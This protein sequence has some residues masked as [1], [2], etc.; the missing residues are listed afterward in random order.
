MPRA[1][2][3]LIFSICLAVSAI[4]QGGDWRQYSSSQAGFKV[5]FPANWTAS[6]E[7][8]W[9]AGHLILQSPEVFDR[10]VMMSAGIR[11]CSQ[12]KG[13]ISSSSDGN[14][15]CRL[16]DDHLSELYKNK[17]VSEEILEI[18]GVKIRKTISQDKYRPDTV[19]IDAFFSTNERDVMINGGFPKKFDL[20]KYVPVFDQIITTIQILTNFTSLTYSNEKYGFSLT[21]PAS[22]RSCALDFRRKKEDI[23]LLVPENKNCAGANSIL[24]SLPSDERVDPKEILS[25]QSFSISAADWSIN[26]RISGSKI[27]D[28]YYYR[29]TYLSFANRSPNLVLVREMYAIDERKCRDEALGILLS[30][31]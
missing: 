14:S 21:Y 7:W 11:I 13:Y 17:I 25:K 1:L 3:L 10:D 2:V 26:S 18:S 12:P 31:K 20:E 27:D 24:I 6:E 29:E 19:Y 15:R 5:K 8:V 23:L 4:G 9:P 28:K 30:L 22:W 16:R